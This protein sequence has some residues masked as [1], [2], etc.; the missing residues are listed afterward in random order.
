MSL[1]FPRNLDNNSK[2]GMVYDQNNLFVNLK[3]FLQ[4]CFTHCV[5]LCLLKTFLIV[6]I[7]PVYFRVEDNTNYYIIM[8][9]FVG[10][11]KC[12]KLTL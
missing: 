12:S 5:Y 6:I 2:V 8:D 1:H 9:Y 3:L 10:L 4:C 11:V 7:K